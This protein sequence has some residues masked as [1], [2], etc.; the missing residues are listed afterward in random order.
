MSTP[1]Q[2]YIFCPF[3]EKKRKNREE[4]GEKEKRGKKKKEKTEKKRRE[5]GE[6]KEIIEK[7][8]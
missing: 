5:R 3:L 1:P 6:K 4:L 8:I 7:N 2:G